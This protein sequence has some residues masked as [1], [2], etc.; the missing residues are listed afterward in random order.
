MLRLYNTLNKKVEEFRPINPPS[1]GIYTCGPT[2][3]RNIHIGNFRTYLMAD[4]LRR[5]LEYNGCNVIHVKNITDVGHMR[6]PVDDN[7]SAGSPQVNQ[8]DPVI[9]E[10][11]KEGKTPREIVGRY[12]GLFLEDER[13]LNIRKADRYPK[14]SEHIKEMIEIIKVLLKKELAYEA[15]GTVYFDVKKFKTYGKLSG[16]TLDKM[17]KLLKAVRVSLETDKKDSIDFALWKKAE[18]GR[19]MKWE[20][21]W[22]IGFPGWHIEC[23]AMSIRYLGDTL[24]IHTGGEDLIFP[25]HE[26]EIAQSE[27]ATGRQFVNYWMHGGYL[28]TDDEKMSRSKGNVYILSDLEKKGFEPMAFRY[29]TMLTHYKSKMNFTWEALSS[30]QTALNRLRA[31]VSKWDEPKIGCAELENK[32]LD[33]IN[34][35]LNMPEALAVVWEL[36]KSDNPT[37][38]KAESLFKFDQILG[39]NLQEAKEKKETIPQDILEMIKQRD[40]FRANKRYLLADQLR[41]KL[42]KLGYNVKDTQK[43]TVMEKI[44]S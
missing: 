33:A 13:K 29:L 20:S 40:D 12:T 18:E 6:I 34:N 32:F 9:E 15:D 35:D 25:H 41:N 24:D 27:G 4:F 7:G 16:N 44:L 39:L 8:I 36:V 30:A 38:A 23:S 28:L 3:Y 14:A 19:L 21:P 42:K 26:D 22:G 31:E 2:V 17:D 11:L 43:G 10:A 37:S 1:V 5:A